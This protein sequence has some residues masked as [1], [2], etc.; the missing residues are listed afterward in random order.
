MNTLVIG[1][2]NLLGLHYAAHRLQ[3]SDSV[4]FVDSGAPLL[5]RTHEEWLRSH[6]TRAGQIMMVYEDPSQMDMEQFINLISNID[7]VLW[8][9]PRSLESTPFSGLLAEHV[10]LVTKILSAVH[11]ESPGAHVLL[12]ASPAVYDLT[13]RTATKAGNIYTWPPG[14]MG[15][16]EMGRELGTVT[17]L[18]AASEMAS[19]HMARGFASQYN[20]NVATMVLSGIYGE[21]TFYGD[22]RSW[23]NRLISSAK[24]GLP[25]GTPADTAQTLDFLDA[26]DAVGAV[27]LLMGY[28]AKYRGG[29][30]NVGGGPANA[31]SWHQLGRMV[32]AQ[33]G[34]PVQLESVGPSP[35][36][37]RYVSNL[38]S[39]LVLGWTPTTTLSE[40]IRRVCAWAKEGNP[41]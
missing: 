27:D 32:S 24:L 9:G 38:T 23:P 7:Q 22:F 39:M 12:T 10:G 37:P 18:A 11:A 2:F 17:S 21:Q 36:P 28:A 34:L 20:T 15:P 5:N 30:F 16:S 35:L 40:G 19:L 3:Q 33:L 4:V 14:S 8:C 29:I 1:G 6:T 26:R 13:R 31:A 25:A 41:I